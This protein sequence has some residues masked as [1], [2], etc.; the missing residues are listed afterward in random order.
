[1][2]ARVRDEAAR[3]QSAP[4]NSKASALLRLLVERLLLRSRLWLGRRSLIGSC[5]CAAA[6]HLVQFGLGFCDLRFGIFEGAVRRR[7]LRRFG[8]ALAEVIQ[9]F[10]FVGDAGLRILE[11][12][13]VR[14]CGGTRRL[15]AHGRLAEVHALGEAI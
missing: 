9:R 10:T 7:L 11:R 12:A 4:L 1:A 8:I 5:L 3:M 2:A 14:T 15:H 13:R 6:A